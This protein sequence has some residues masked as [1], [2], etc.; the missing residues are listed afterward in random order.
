MLDQIAQADAMGDVS[1]SY[2]G[3]ET[4]DREV[5]AALEHSEQGMSRSVL[6][7]DEGQYGMT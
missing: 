4:S 3:G 1:E 6:V 2:S 7:E 5:S